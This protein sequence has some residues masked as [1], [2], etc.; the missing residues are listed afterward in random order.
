MQMFFQVTTNFVPCSF[1]NGL[2]VLLI[3]ILYLKTLMWAFSNYF[4]CFSDPLP[5]L[6]NLGCFADGWNRALPVPYANMR[7]QIVW[8]NMNKTVSECAHIARDKGY[9]Y[10]GVQFYGE[11][12]SAPDNVA[13]A[14]YN[15]HGAADNCVWGVGADWSNM[16]YK[17]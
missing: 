8:T 12:W 5:P 3:K 1:W 14:N 11:C 13:S 9:S 15:K 10:F 2:M 6:T 4:W 7:S 16:V 17:M